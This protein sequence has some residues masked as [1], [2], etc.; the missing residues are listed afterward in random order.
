MVIKIKNGDDVTK[1]LFLTAAREADRVVPPSRHGRGITIPDFSQRL[2][3]D[4]VSRLT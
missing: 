1:G 3:I 2:R 4:T